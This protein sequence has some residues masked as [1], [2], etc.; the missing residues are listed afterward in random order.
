MQGNGNYDPYSPDPWP[1]N[2]TPEQYAQWRAVNGYPPVQQ[3]QPSPTPPMTN[4]QW[5]RCR[6]RSWA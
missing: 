6:P 4:E 5:R 1:D 3:S 2:M